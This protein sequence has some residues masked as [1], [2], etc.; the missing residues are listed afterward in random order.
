MSRAAALFQWLAA[1]TLKVTIE[2]VR[3]L[4]E[5]AEAHAALEAR[6][7]AGKLLLVP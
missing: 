5:A 3:P 7:T 4:A 1:G 2:R 6:A